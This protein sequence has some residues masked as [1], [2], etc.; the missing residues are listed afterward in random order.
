MNR[1]KIEL[2]KQ[3]RSKAWLARKLGVHSTTIFKY[4]ANKNQPSAQ[5]IKEI[6]E[7]LGVTMEDLI[8]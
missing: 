2:E 8:V 4:C 6:A 1:I 7:I 5:R 3:E